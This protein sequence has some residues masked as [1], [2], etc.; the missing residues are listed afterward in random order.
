MHK[1]IDTCIYSVH[2]ALC[3]YLLQ[4]KSHPGH[5]VVCL[6]NFV[7]IPEPF[8]SILSVGLGW[9]YCYVFVA[10]SFT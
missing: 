3:R 2:N 9:E 5:G 4:N 1:L 8:H 6:N 10:V 7:S